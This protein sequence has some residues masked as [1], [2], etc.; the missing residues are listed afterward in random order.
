MPLI[1]EHLRTSHRGSC[2]TFYAE[3]SCTCGAQ[4]EQIEH[5]WTMELV[6]SMSHLIEEDGGPKWA[7]ASGYGDYW[8]KSVD[9]T[10]TLDYPLP[11]EPGIK[12]GDRIRMWRER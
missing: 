8:D 5:R 2:R 9:H 3:S 12:K 1:T 10:F 4:W 11:D 7:H 6:L